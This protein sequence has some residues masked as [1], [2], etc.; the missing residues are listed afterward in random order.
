VMPAVYAQQV[1]PHLAA[2]DLVSF[3]SGY[4]IAFG[5]LEPAADLDVVLVARA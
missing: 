4:N 1:A 2:G 3:A 5:L